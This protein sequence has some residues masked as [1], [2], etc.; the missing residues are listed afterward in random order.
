LGE[1]HAQPRDVID[2]SLIDTCVHTHSD[3]LADFKRLADRVPDMQAHIAAE[4]EKRKTIVAEETERKRTRH[5]MATAGA[6]Q[7]DQPTRKHH[8]DQKKRRA[9]TTATATVTAVRPEREDEEDADEYDME[10]LPEELNAAK[11]EP[12]Q[13]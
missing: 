13:G 11:L 4:R 1:S 6:T 9:T 2:S 5:T 8:R 7:P 3:I 12:G 10:G